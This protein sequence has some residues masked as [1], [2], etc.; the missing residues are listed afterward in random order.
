MAALAIVARPYGLFG[1]GVISSIRTLSPISFAIAKA[2]ALTLVV[3]TVRHC[4]FS[5]TLTT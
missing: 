2:F 5:N 3:S 4:G 1:F